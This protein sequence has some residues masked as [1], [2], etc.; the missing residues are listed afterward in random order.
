MIKL[1][2]TDLDGTLLSGEKHIP[3]D[4]DEVLE[5]LHR[6]GI[7]FAVAT[8]RNFE[9]I[10]RFFQDKIEKLYFICDNGAYIMEKGKVTKCT[11]ID[12]NTCCEVFNTIKNY[13]GIDVL[14]CGKK[15]TYYTH[16]LPQMMSLMENFYAK[17]TFADDMCQIDDE[18][19][20]ISINDMNDPLKSGSY[21]FMQDKFGD[22]LSIHPSGSIWMDMMQK[23]INKAVG[24]KYLQNILGITKEE[25]MIFGDYFNDIP[26]LECA[27][28]SF[29]M[30]NA[31]DEV[32]QHAKYTAQNCDK[33]G[34]TKAIKEYV[35]NI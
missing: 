33:Q 2:I 32:K 24:V 29:A 11:V 27:E 3:D 5:K 26:M 34:V 18:I 10:R 15:G 8:G 22:V 25:T 19:F 14:A 4:F 30:E 16:S 20:K 9:G 13:E 21:Q 23:D 31:P 7:I 17:T 28:Y 1:I 6:K 35:L 12:K